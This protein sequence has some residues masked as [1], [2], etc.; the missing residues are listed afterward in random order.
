MLKMATIRIDFARYSVMSLTNA[1]LTYLFVGVYFHS[2]FLLINH[3][4]TAEK[5]RAVKL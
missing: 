3:S 1:A 2:F 4:A 5:T